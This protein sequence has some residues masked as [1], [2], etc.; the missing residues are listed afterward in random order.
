VQDLV[1]VL[2]GKGFYAPYGEKVA[3]DNTEKLRW[4][5]RGSWAGET[6]ESWGSAVVTGA[7]SVSEMHAWLKQNPDA[8]VAAIR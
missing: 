7:V 6:E 8:F 5:V 2:S 1:D 4:Y 3:A